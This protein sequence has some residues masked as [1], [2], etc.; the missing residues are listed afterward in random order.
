MQLRRKKEEEE[1]EEKEKRQQD[2]LPLMVLSLSLFFS[3][4]LFLP[5]APPKF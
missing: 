5:P 4:S 1:E 3:A 2:F